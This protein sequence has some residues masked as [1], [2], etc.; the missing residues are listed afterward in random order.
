MTEFIEKNGYFSIERMELMK[1]M[2]S[3]GDVQIT[4]QA[5]TMS[6]RAAL[7]VIISKHFGTEIIDELFD[8]FYAKTQELPDQFQPSYKEETPL[9]LV[10]KRK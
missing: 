8:R 9:G 4:G 10:L 6:A 7:E 5:L 1:P 2:S 3:T